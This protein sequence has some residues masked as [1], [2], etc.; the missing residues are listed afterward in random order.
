MSSGV[1]LYR[2]GDNTERHWNKKKP[3]K[4]LLAV[5]ITR[6]LTPERNKSL[7]QRKNVWGADHGQTIVLDNIATGTGWE[8]NGH[9]LR[10]EFIHAV[11]YKRSLKTRS[12]MMNLTTSAATGRSCWA[13]DQHLEMNLQH[14][15][16][17]T[18]PDG[19][20]GRC[21]NC[22]TRVISSK[23]VLPWKGTS[24]D[25][26]YP[27]TW[28][29][30]HLHSEETHMI[31]DPA[32]RVDVAFVSFHRAKLCFLPASKEFRCTPAQ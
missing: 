8:M 10:L 28:S 5:S 31:Q 29:T 30:R 3:F 23:S 27:N 19:L 1:E 6:F 21:R 13:E 32:K 15:S 9:R 17:I 18:S 16:G 12:L 4:M 20:S 14:E 24:P 11:V 25:K 7:P 2:I 26:T 22:S